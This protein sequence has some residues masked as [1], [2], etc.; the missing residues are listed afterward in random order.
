MPSEASDDSAFG[1]TKTK[2][3]IEEAVH[4][5]CKLPAEERRK[6]LKALRLKWHP[7]KHEVP[8]P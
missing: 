8:R 3:A 2:A 7:D 1:L 6:K 5:A 4:E